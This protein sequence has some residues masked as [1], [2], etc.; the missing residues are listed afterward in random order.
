M[1]T[2]WEKQH[3]YLYTHTYLYLHAQPEHPQNDLL[4]A[5]PFHSPTPFLQPTPPP[6]SPNFIIRITI[7]TICYVRMYPCFWGKAHSNRHAQKQ[8]LISLFSIPETTAYFPVFHPRNNSLFPCFPSQKQQL[9]S[10]FSIPET[11]AYFPVFHPRN[12]SL[13]PHFPSQKQQLISP[14]S[15]PETTAYFPVFHPRNNSL[16]PRFPSQKQQLIS[17]FS[18]PETTAYFP[19]FHPRNNSLFPCFPS[20][21]RIIHYICGLSKQ[22]GSSSAPKRRLRNTHTHKKRPERPKVTHLAHESIHTKCLNFTKL[23][24]ADIHTQF[25]P[26]FNVPM[27]RKEQRQRDA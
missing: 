4:F 12:N 26:L 17:L 14:F 23:T 8:Q 25:L 13:F 21:K 16:F 5:L 20:Q 2:Q 11:T 7:C 3:S 24:P 27:Q 6:I 18:I 15:I 1:Y 10:L 9:I 19:V 22:R